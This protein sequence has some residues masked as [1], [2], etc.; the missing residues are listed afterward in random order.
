MTNN[1]YSVIALVKDFNTV[2]ELSS[3][4]PGVTWI[5]LDLERSQDTVVKCLKV[6][7]AFNYILNFSGIPFLD[8]STNF[9]RTI[10]ISLK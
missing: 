1:S 6:L 10:G 2:G 3:Q 9:Y 7:P 8:T 4:Y 5:V